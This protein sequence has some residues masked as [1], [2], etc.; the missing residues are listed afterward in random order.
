MQWR[1]TTA[2]KEALKTIQNPQEK[3]EKE[4][5]QSDELISTILSCYRQLSILMS[6]TIRP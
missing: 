5:Q 1:Q 4:Q 2:H 6:P 3:K